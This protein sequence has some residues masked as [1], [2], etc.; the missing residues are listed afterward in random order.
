MSIRVSLESMKVLNCSGCSHKDKWVK[1]EKPF[2]NRNRHK[3][4]TKCLF[5][6]QARQNLCSEEG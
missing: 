1:S 3:S 4:E 6:E 5:K 2:A